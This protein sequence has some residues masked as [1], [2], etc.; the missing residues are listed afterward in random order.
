MCP[1]EAA[2]QR[3]LLHVLARDIPPA[4]KLLATA[5]GL[6]W[7][8]GEHPGHLL[9]PLFARLLGAQTRLAPPSADPD[10]DPSTAGQDEERLAAPEIEALVEHAGVEGVTDSTMRA[11]VLAAMKEA[12]QNRIAG[13]TEQKRRR[14]YGHAADLVATCIACDGTRE[15][16]RWAAA[17]KADYRRFPALRDE[18]DRALGTS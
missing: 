8:D 6:G 3:A 2:R 7:S 17:L 4:A 12:A 18:L 15:T 14:Q 16:M 13:V 9:F 1:K 10:L 5:P 11:T